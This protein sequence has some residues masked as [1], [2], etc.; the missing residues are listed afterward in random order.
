MAKDY[1][2]EDIMWRRLGSEDR[3]ILWI[4]QQD[5]ELAGR[6]ATCVGDVLGKYHPHGDASVYDALVRL[7]QDFSM[8]YPLVD[9]HGNFGSVDG[10]PPA[11][12]LYRGP[13]GQ[14]GRGYAGGI[15]RKETV[16]WDPNF[17]ESRKE[18]RVS[19]RPVP[20]PAG[21][22]ILR[23]RRGH[24][25]EHSPPQ[26]AGSDQCDGVRSGQPGGG[27]S[28]TSCST[29]PDRISPQRASSWAV[30]ASAPPTPPAA[31]GWWSGPGMSLRSTATMSVPAS[32]SPSCPIR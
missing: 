14:N 18:P 20:Q 7:A 4:V 19:P 21:Q 32:L 2:P 16:D 5:E 31:A 6:S 27:G 1:K 22:R 8:R 24:G 13:H 17:D 3:P 11:L 30:P 12:P 25:H 23:H 29:S 9:G 28:P 26:P 15:S 10:D